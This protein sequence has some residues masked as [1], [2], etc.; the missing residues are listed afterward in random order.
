MNN[1]FSKILQPEKIAQMQNIQYSEK[2][3]LTDNVP[4]NTSKLGKVSIS[5]LGAFMCLFITG[6]FETLQLVALA[7]TD[8]GVSFLRGK[9]IDGS[10][11]RQLF[12][13]FIPLDLFLS[14]GRVKSSN[15]VNVATD[16]VSN[17]LF[18]PL[19]FQYLFAENSEILFDVKNDSDTVLKYELVF[20]GIRLP[21]A[22]RER[23]AKLAAMQ[24]G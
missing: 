2:L 10:N 18:Y 23:N 17:N 15:S 14:P 20:H 22:P 1:L 5:S 21:V 11:Q 16:P 9:L 12:N 4:A 13:D 19:Q 6:H 8:T 7:I 3:L 24:R